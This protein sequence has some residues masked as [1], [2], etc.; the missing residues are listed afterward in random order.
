MLKVLLDTN[1]L[2]DVILKRDPWM[3][4]GK[5]ILEAGRDGRRMEAY[6]ASLSLKDVYF[7]STKILGEPQA[8]AFL[9]FIMESCQVLAV[10]ART[11]AAA[12]AGPEPDFEDGLVAAA[13]LEG[14]MDAIIS[15]DTAA[16]GNL[17]IPKIDPQ[18]FARFFLSESPH[19]AQTG[20]HWG[21]VNL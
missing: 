11:C 12:L 4:Y 6:V 14:G 16:F 3:E 15:R 19:P 8:R 9:Q 5:S 20:E 13:T 10:G 1:I 17:P 21:V 7:V 18:L 2:L